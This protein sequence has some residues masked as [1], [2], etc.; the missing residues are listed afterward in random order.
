MIVV[1][2]GAGFI[3]SAIVHT[4]NQRGI[5]D[6]L[7]VDIKDHPEKEK[8]L[9]YL[10]YGFFMDREDFLRK[11]QTRQLKG[12]ETIFHMGAC[13]S[14]TETDETFLNKNNLEYTQELTLFAMEKDVRFIYASSAATYGNGKQG[15]SDNELYLDKYH[16]LNLYG[17]SKHNFDLWAKEKGLLSSIVGLKYFNVFGPNEYHK[18]DMRSMV[19]KGY[20][21]ARDQ[22]YIQL[23][24]SYRPD[25]SHGGQKR[26][27]IYIKDAVR[28][29][30]FFMDNPNINGIYNVGT[31]KARTWKDL[32][33]SIFSA[34]G[35]DTTIQFIEMPESIQEQ[36]QY[37]TQADIKKICAAGFNESLLSLEDSIQDYVKNFLLPKKRL[38]Q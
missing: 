25:Y 3:G 27:F 6:I 18:E 24:K 17:K 4:L 14:T 20:F 34:I 19:L 2:G 1:T 26:D 15:Y 33:V 5:T 38:G 10:R 32:A 12:V 37:Y 30:L 7:I 16:P 13:S 35:K 28:M 29:T 11:V 22:G 31:G 23:F 21:Q 36:Y 9:T 8:N